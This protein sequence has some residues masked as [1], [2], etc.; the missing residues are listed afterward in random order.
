MGTFGERLAKLR[1]ERGLTQ[2]QLAKHLQI[3]K[4]TLA[5]YE[6]NKREPDFET[7]IF[8]SKFFE[9]SIDYLL[10]GKHK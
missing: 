6:T 1:K 4:S 3:S 10:M 8:I 5:M 7:L 9:V 2:K